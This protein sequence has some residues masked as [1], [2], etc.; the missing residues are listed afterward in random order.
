VF[1]KNTNFSFVDEVESQ[2]DMSKFIDFANLCL[3][4]VNLS[5]RNVDIVG[6]NVLA[7]IENLTFKE[8]KGFE[9]ERFSTRL[10]LSEKGIVARYL[11]IKTPQSRVDLDVKF[12]TE[13]WEDYKEFVSNVRVY[14]K[15][16]NTSLDFED[17]VYFAP[18]LEGKHNQFKISGSI[19]GYVNDFRAKDFDVSYGQNTRF[20]G[21]VMMSG[22]PD[23]NNTFFDLSIRNLTTTPQDV[24]DFLLPNDNKI[25]VPKELYKL[26]QTSLSG[27]ITGLP[28][29]LNA[30][31]N[32][33]TTMGRIQTDFKFSHDIPKETFDFSGHIDHLL[34]ALGDVLNEKTLGNNLNLSG[35]FDGRFSTIHGMDLSTNIVCENVEY[36]NRE[37]NTVSIKGDWVNQIISAAISIEDDDGTAEFSGELSTDPKNT[38]LEAHGFFKDVNLTAFQLVKDTNQPLFS[39]NFSGKIY[40][41]NIDYLAGN[42]SFSNL[43][44]KMKDTTFYLNNFTASQQILPQGFSTT[45]E[46]STKLKIDC[47]FFNTEIFGNYKFSNID[48]IW[49]DIQKNYLSALRLS[50]DDLKSLEY[51]DLHYPFKKTE[52]EQKHLASQTLDLTLNMQKTGGIFS[53]F[54]PEI[55][56]PQGAKIEFGYNGNHQ[57]LSLSV[58]TKKATVYG[59]HISSLNLKG[60][61]HD[62][63][64]VINADAEGL[65]IKNSLSVEDFSIAAKFEDD[66]ISWKLD[67][68]ENS[69]QNRPINGNFDG[70]MTIL[71]NAKISFNIEYS[72]LFFSNQHW[73][74]D[75]NNTI[76]VD[77]VGVHFQNVRFFNQSDSSEYLK[78]NGDLSRNRNSVLN[79]AFNR[80]QLA[81][82]TPLIERT[83]LYFDGAISGEIDI[84][85]FYNN[86]RFNTNLQ[87]EDFSMN[88]FNYGMAFL[89]TTANEKASESHINFAIRNNGTNYLLADGY[90][91]PNRKDK[92]FDLKISTSDLDLSLLENYVET[93]SS[94][95]TGKLSA[96]LTLDGT[97][98]KPNL[99]GDLTLDDAVMKV[100]FLN[101]FYAIKPEKI[102]FS[103]DSIIFVNTTLEDVQNKTKGVLSGGLYHHRFQNFRLNLG[104][105]M[106]NL[107]A[108]NTNFQHNETF[109]G[110]VFIT[111]NARLSGPVENILIDVLGRTE[112]GTELQI[113][114]SARLNISESNQFIHFV[115]PQKEDV[116]TLVFNGRLSE[117]TTT[118]NMTVRLNID[119]TPD[120]TAI[121]DMDAPPISGLI[122]A[123]GSG[124]LRMNFE[125]RTQ[126]FALFGD[127][128]LQDGIFDFMFEDRS[129]GLGNVVPRRFHIER[130]GTLQWMGDPGNMI[131]DVSAIYSTRAS[132][133]PILSSL[134]IDDNNSIQRVNVQSVI[135]LRGRMSNPDIKFDFRLPNV[136]DETRTR[137]FSVLNRDDENEMSQQTFS[138]LLFGTFTA[139]G[140]SS[141][142]VQGENMLA[143]ML[144]RQVSNIVQNF[145]GDNIN[146]GA[147]YRPGD[148]N[149]TQLW[150]A[151]ASAQFLDNRL[152]IDGHIGQ[153]GL[154]NI[155]G[156]DPGAQQM[157]MHEVNL[158][159]RWTNTLSLKA[160]QR[161]NEREFSR[162]A[163]LGYLQGFGIA[164]RR[165][166]DSFRPFSLFRRR[167]DN[168]EE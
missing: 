99:H 24:D 104:L 152:L 47:D 122:N 80:Y 96:K 140:N 97:L 156:I 132:L 111:G 93:F 11:D 166:F 5:A 92:N 69:G 54:L 31:V 30:S 73:R 39:S 160:F 61:S 94:S 74:F 81:P 22:L 115:T 155:T 141:N 139:P 26:G 149:N 124:N 159:W 46:P 119:V 134:G 68:V 89:R 48:A 29:D 162:G 130:G 113:N 90:F 13:S 108:M 66:F 27:Q 83:G 76:I 72:D 103:L 85:D 157:V 36:Q 106:N 114:H 121:F 55:D 15:L 127:Y 34:L 84:F 82:W 77:T 126:Q 98:K 101:T 56:L 143:N 107:F 168:V 165:E 71:D 37:I 117:T 164:Y 163:Q 45:A 35:S 16:R 38:Y 150:Q 154:S 8:K 142:T 118:N 7:T 146:F 135:S 110:R 86:L 105:Q 57:P 91:Y 120:A 133:A 6:G 32:I 109:F 59:F 138:L 145:I 44:M 4:N 125:S 161:P 60:T 128:V 58:V 153:G 20:F 50:V 148:I 21:D 70:S 28:S 78:L 41:F 95:L 112:R 42:V 100:D 75:P 64:L 116:D 3:K 25:A 137:F 18:G 131:L 62:S 123:Q 63:V 2:G 1:L 87:I 14:A 51:K 17:L 9:V 67:W 88:Q 158:E 19:L 147:N 23:F 12:T 136:D 10:N 129:L 102:M 167:N 33:I 151:T 43:K 49:N 52:N 144:S 40:S 79:L 53:Y 65:K